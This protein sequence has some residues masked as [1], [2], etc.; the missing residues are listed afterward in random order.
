MAA[1]DFYNVSLDSLTQ[2][3]HAVSGEDAKARNSREA[4]WLGA[5]RQLP[6]SEADHILGYILARTAPP[7]N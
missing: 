6:E 4:L 7:K 2:R 5:F 3:A 1:A